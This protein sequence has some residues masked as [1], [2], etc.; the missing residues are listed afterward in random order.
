MVKAKL[1]NRIKKDGN[2]CRAIALKGKDHC[3]NHTNSPVW[4]QSKCDL[5]DHCHASCQESSSTLECGHTVHDGCLLLFVKERCNGKK[6][7]PVCYKWLEP[8][9]LAEHIKE[10]IKAYGEG[11]INL[12]EAKTL[13]KKQ[14]H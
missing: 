14:Y 4:C 6:R 13:L 2:L 8:F 7:C 1:C 9:S 11:L 10:T 12:K 5:G 3:R